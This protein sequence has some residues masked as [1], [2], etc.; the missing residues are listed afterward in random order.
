MEYKF[1]IVKGCFDIYM[2]MLFVDYGILW[3]FYYIKYVLFDKMVC[4]NQLF[5]F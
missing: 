5:F 1:D 3:I 4:I 2:Y